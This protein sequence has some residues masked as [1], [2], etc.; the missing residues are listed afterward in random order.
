MKSSAQFY[1]YCHWC[2]DRRR[3]LHYNRHSDYKCDRYN[4]G[5]HDGEEADGWPVSDQPLDHGDRYDSDA[6]EQSKFDL[7]S[8]SSSSLDSTEESANLEPDV[9]DVGAGETPGNG[10]SLKTIGAG[11]TDCD[12]GLTL[13]DDE[14]SGVLTRLPVEYS[15]SALLCIRCYSRPRR[16]RS[17]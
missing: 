16:I 12:G 1:F 11:D 3:E 17:L 15:T 2:L 6:L 14:R 10:S 8:S 9:V 5:D 13:V 7:S 4:S